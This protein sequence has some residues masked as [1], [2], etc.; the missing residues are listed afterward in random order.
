MCIKTDLER[1]VACKTFD[2]IEH[3]RGAIRRTVGEDVYFDKLGPV[4]AGMAVIRRTP[5]G[6]QWGCDLVA[7][8][9]D[10]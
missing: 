10:R 6:D 2:N 8:V 9:L 1:L 3:L 5:I 4:Q 7:H